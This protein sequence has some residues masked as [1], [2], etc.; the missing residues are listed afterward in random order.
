MLH[1]HAVAVFFLSLLAFVDQW[2][3]VAKMWW[4]EMR[5]TPRGET[6]D[7]RTPC[8][9]RDTFEHMESAFHVSVT[10]GISSREHVR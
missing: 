5:A 3:L 6:R 7:G 9:A 2:L 1:G 10:Q 8:D 4:R